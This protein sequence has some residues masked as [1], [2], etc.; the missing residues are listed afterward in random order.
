LLYW[1]QMVSD[2]TLAGEIGKR[3]E[4]VLVDEYQDTQGVVEKARKRQIGQGHARGDALF[5]RAI[6]RGAR[7]KHA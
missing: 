2:P 5:A 7:K 3:F 4:H 1:A 6:R